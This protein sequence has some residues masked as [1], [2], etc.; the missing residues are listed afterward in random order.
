MT[1]F[2]RAVIGSQP[3]F[4]QCLSSKE[5]EEWNAIDW[6]VLPGTGEHNTSAEEEEV[7]GELGPPPLSWMR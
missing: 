4:K 5:E 6:G 2:S 7:G 1:S 3:G